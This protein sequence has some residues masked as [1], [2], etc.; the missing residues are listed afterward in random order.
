MSSIS[1]RNVTKS[2]GDFTAVSDLNLEIADG[3][4]L[5]LLGPSGCGKTTTMNMVAGIESA[6]SGDLLFDGKPPAAKRLQDRGIGFVFQ[7]YAIFTHL[8]V[9]ENLAF[10]LSVKKTPQPEIDRRVA[11]MAK[12]MSIEHRLDQLSGSLSVNEMQKVAIARSAIA[13]PKVFLLDEPLSNL[14]AG[15]RAYM[16]AELKILQHEF[17]QTMVYVTHDQIEAMSLA[18]RIAIMDRGQLM[19]VGAPLDV[20]N[21]PANVFVARFV[22]S[23]AINLLEGKLTTTGSSTSLRLNGGEAIELPPSLAATCLMSSSNQVLLGIRAQEVIAGP[24]QASTDI[25]IRGLVEVVERLGPVKVAHVHTP[26]GVVKCM[27]G[28][29]AS[30]VG[31]VLTVSLA[32]SKCLAFDAL[33][34]NRLNL[35]DH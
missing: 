19:Q 28:V 33:T 7:N 12:R 35:L 29:G 14:D 25:T 15:F 31:D 13:E 1:L 16:R 23:P 17:K 11:A 2:F 8:S 6:T 22:G 18:D 24:P 21:N 32:Q 3:E 26:G 9:R 20:Y 10:S 30:R 4:F 34:G 27:Q 5:A